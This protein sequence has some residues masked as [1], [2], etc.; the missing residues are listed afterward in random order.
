[1][2]PVEGN[3]VI[4]DAD[5]GKECMRRKGKSCYIQSLTDSLHKVGITGPVG[6]AGAEGE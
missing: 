5:K 6:K 4:D 1:M 3:S 2:R